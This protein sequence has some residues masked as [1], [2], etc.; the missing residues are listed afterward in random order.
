[1]FNIFLKNKYLEVKDFKN[2]FISGE[3][4]YLMFTEN[5]IHNKFLYNINYLKIIYKNNEY[6]EFKKNM[7]I[8]NNNTNKVIIENYL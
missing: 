4:F 5:S 6:I 8:F 3:N 2:V 1:M 7:T